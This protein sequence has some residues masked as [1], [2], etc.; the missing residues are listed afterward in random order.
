MDT[1]IITLPDLRGLSKAEI[2]E[3][4]LIL[5]IDSSGNGDTVVQQSPEP[6][7]KIKVR[8]PIRPYFG[9]DE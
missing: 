4:L 3:Q 2:M 7:T 1:S 5:K 6:G 9:Q 8:S